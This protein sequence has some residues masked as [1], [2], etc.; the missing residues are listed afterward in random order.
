MALTECRGP[1]G[2][3]IRRTVLPDAAYEAAAGRAILL[4]PFP[5]P[6]RGVRYPGRDCAPAGRPEPAGEPAPNRSFMP[7]LPQ[8]VGASATGD[9]D[10]LVGLLD[11]S[12]LV[13]GGSEETEH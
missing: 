7:V 5:S 3:A 9:M 10:A 4:F 12:W 1:R 13:E 6:A 8:T 2:G 11:N